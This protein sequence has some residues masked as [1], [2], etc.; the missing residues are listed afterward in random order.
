MAILILEDG[1]IFKGE[2]FGAEG[3]VFG[4]LV[5]NTSMMGYQEIITD[6][7]SANQVLVMTYPE[8]GNCGINDNAFEGEKPAIKALIVKNYFA[9]ES[10]YKSQM[11][12]GEYL[13]Q[14][15]VVA[16][17][18]FDT[19]ALTR[20]I[21]SGGTQRCFVTTGEIENIENTLSLLKAY[22]PE[23]DKTFKT[24]TLGNGAT[25]LGVVD[26]GIN[27]SILKTL[28][29]L[30]CSV[31]N[32]SPDFKTE[33]VEGK[34]DALVLS[35]GCGTPQEYPLDSLKALLGKLP[36]LGV[37]IGAQIV[38]LA[39]D[40]R[41]RK[42]TY[43]H[44]GANQPVMSLKDAKTL[45]TVQNHSWSVDE[46]SLCCETKAIY[47]N[48]NDDSLEG[49]ECKEKNVCGIEFYPTKDIFDGW[50]KGVRK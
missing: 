36:I 20:K 1:S 37:C 31:T 35:G 39:L 44:R 29:E 22:K 6:P 18:G 5:F 45:I 15:N 50:L 47:K 48:L 43:G 10:H 12:L 32:L 49:F 3:E 8:I 2:S 40:A 9:K 14:N 38:A 13:K 17:Q 26:Y 19:R 25:R 42:L 33:D 23:T 4:E 24:R 28:A 16:L 41:V 11:S 27:N 7:A 30:G 46:D 21:R 34:Y